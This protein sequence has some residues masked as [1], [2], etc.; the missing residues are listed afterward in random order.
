M[1]KKMANISS[2]SEFMP[3]LS[4]GS[5]WRRTAI[6][7]IGRHFLTGVRG[8]LKSYMEIG[9]LSALIFAVTKDIFFTITL[10]LT[11]TLMLILCKSVMKYWFFRFRI[12]DH[13]IEILSGIFH[14]KHLNLPFGQI[15]QISIEQPAYYKFFGN[16]VDAFLDSAGTKK[17]EVEISALPGD[18]AVLIRLKAEEAK[19]CDV[20]PIQNSV[21]ARSPE[22]EIL[23]RHNHSSLLLYGVLQNKLLWFV[24]I[25]FGFFEKIKM[26]VPKLLE[27]YPVEIGLIEKKLPANINDELGLAVVLVV[28][29]ICVFLAISSLLAWVKHFSYTLYKTDDGFMSVQGLLSK[30]QTHAKK[31]KVQWVL[32]KRNSIERM[33]GR[34]NVN[35]E[36]FGSSL[37]APCLTSMQCNDILHSV[38]PGHSQLDGNF[39]RGSPMYLVKQL[40]TVCLPLLLLAGAFASVDKVTQNVTILVYFTLALGCG[41]AVFFFLQ[42]YRRGFFED[43]EYFYIRKGRLIEKTYIIPKYKLQAASISQ[44]WFMKRNGL[45]TC[46][47]YFANGRFKLPYICADKGSAIVTSGLEAVQTANTAWV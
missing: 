8:A 47:L 13:H 22:S 27:I 3:N 42:W 1:V 10:V 7:A 41:F 5:E 19:N 44:S 46:T 17:N 24:A 43:N 23:L 30:V 6:L 33:L 21:D 28:F 34:Q 15:Q 31:R 26:A 20:N 36:Q 18:V 11:L 45:S 16:Y 9:G 40:L 35:I 39:K 38:M 37:E 25:L 2:A 32:I 12:T 4:Q 29:A 14:R